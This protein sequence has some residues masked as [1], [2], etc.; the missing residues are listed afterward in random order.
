[1]KLNQRTR[2]F[3]EKMGLLFEHGGSTR[4]HGRL[5]ALLLVHDKPLSLSEMADHLQVSK[6]SLSTNA[7]MAVQIGMAQRVSR[8]GDRK[9]YYQMTP[10]SFENMVAQRVQAIDVFIHLADE[11]LAAV[12]ADNTTARA[13]LEKMKEFYQFFL[14]ELEGSLDRWREHDHSRQRR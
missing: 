7:R 2:E 11:G 8:P 13:R 3:I 4:T 1:M 14:R 6:A 9:D 5:M 10:S 12:E